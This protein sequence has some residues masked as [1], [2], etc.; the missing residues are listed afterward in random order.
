ME[1]LAGLACAL[2]A[3][4]LVGHGIW[5]LIAAMIRAASTPDRP[6]PPARPRPVRREECPGC[7]A[8]LVPGDRDCPKCGLPLD[9]RTARRLDRVRTAEREVRELLDHD[10]LDRETADRVLAQLA[11]RADE[12][13]HPPAEP[14]AAPPP[15]ARLIP[16]AAATPPVNVPVA[17]P[18][19][20]PQSVEPPPAEPGPRRGVLA[21]FMEERNILWGEV[22]G[23][24]LIVGCSI[25]LVLSLW[26]TLEAVPYFPFLLAAAIT[27]AVFAAG[28]YTLHHWK[29][30]ATSRGL[31]IIALLLAPLNLLLLAGP[32][33]DA[34]VGWLDA[35]VKLA[36]V[37]AFVGMV[38]AGGRDLIGTALLPGPIDRR[39][40]LA[41]AVVG[42]PTSQL[43]P[44]TEVSWLHTWL[45]AVWHTGACGAVL[46]GLTWY[47]GR[48]RHVP[49]TRPQ[50]LAVLTFVGLNLPTSC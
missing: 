31:L 10:A 6:T 29:L 40:L 23:G 41:A 14:S 33:A 39:W 17:P 37:A 5:V 26:R 44:T 50:G 28:Q 18:L 35:G 15:V 49:L 46:A 38:R 30:A 24:L 4:T 32:G 34:G 3:V 45:P 2:V 11:R 12:L 48:E 47:R 1:V 25:A 8:R 43:L 9:G 13:L 42:S 16:P 36:A 19:D 7:A 21:A 27:A 20:E 22:V